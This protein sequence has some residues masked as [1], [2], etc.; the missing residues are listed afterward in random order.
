MSSSHYSK[1]ADARRRYDL[2]ETA[3][4]FGTTESLVTTLAALFV[5]RGGEPTSVISTLIGIAT[6]PVTAYVLGLPA[7]PPH[8]DR[9]SAPEFVGP[10]RSV[11]VCAVVA[12]LGR[13]T[14]QHDLLR[15]T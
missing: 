13:Y 7:P 8:V 4:T 5:R 3:S 1:Y 10:R 2:V 11:Q 12:L 15:T 9:P 6:I 14:S